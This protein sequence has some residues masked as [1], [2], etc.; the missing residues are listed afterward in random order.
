MSFVSSK[1]VKGHFLSFFGILALCPDSVCLIYVSNEIPHG[2][3]LALRYSMNCVVSSLLYVI[4]CRLKDLPICAGFVKNGR[5]GV[6]AGFCFALVHVCVTYAFVVENA[7]TVLIVLAT[8]PIWAAIASYIFLSETPPFRT[9]LCGCICLSCVTYM[10]LDKM[11]NREV[12]ENVCV[13]HKNGASG[14]RDCCDERFSNLK[15]YNKCVDICM[16]DG[17][18]GISGSVLG[19]FA[20]ILAAISFGVYFMLL[21]MIS[22]DGKDEDNDEK[23]EGNPDENTSQPT[24]EREWVHEDVAR[25]ATKGEYKAGGL[26]QVLPCDILAALFAAVVGACLIRDEISLGLEAGLVLFVNSAIILPVSFTLLTLSPAY[27]S[28]PEVSLYCLIETVIGPLF[29]WLGGYEKPGKADF[30]GGSILLTSLAVN[31][32]LGIRE[33]SHVCIPESEGDHSE[34]MAN[35][36]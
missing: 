22:L 36:C 29:V 21:R 28:A 7:A 23:L 10:C 3:L 5:R 16:N 19:L 17:D 13:G 14:C 18:V 4:A 24:Q 8:S 32:I 1:K 31:S 11:L 30:V 6:L 33:E 27:I 15:Q 12:E 35:D 20:A 9:V 2:A 34:D 26:L 25:E